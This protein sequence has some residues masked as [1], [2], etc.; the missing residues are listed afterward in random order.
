MTRDTN[1]TIVE[2]YFEAVNTEDASIFE[3]I[4]SSD[5]VLHAAAELNKEAMKALLTTSPYPGFVTKI[6]DMVIDEDK[7]AV[8]TTDSYTQKVQIGTSTPTE[9]VAKYSHFIIFH[10]KDGL[11][12]EAWN[13][14][15]HLSRFQQLGLLPPTEEIG[16]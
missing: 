2:K 7:I 13:L 14:V 11:I 12:T 15:D 8:R 6:E 10:L 9:K 16:K 5:F 3:E 4:L 1:I